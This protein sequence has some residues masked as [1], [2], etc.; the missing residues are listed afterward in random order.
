MLL[1][2]GGPPPAWL[3]PLLKQHLL[4]E[5]HHKV[6]RRLLHLLAPL[7]TEHH[8][9]ISTRHGTSPQ[10]IRALQ[11]PS[12]VQGRARPATGSV[13]GDASSK[14]PDQAMHYEQAASAERAVHAEHSVQD[15]EQFHRMT[16]EARHLSVR[17]EGLRCLGA[18]L[19]PI[20]H[21]LRETSN[22]SL[23]SGM[24]QAPDL[25]HTIKNAGQPQ[26]T[27]PAQS[28]LHS[29]EAHAAQ[30]NT[31]APGQ[32]QSPSLG[33]DQAQPGS[34]L[35]QIRGSV[36]DPAHPA[37]Q[38]PSATEAWQPGTHQHTTSGASGQ[39]E[40][41]DNLEQT[42]YGLVDDFIRLIRRSSEAQQ[43]DDMR[44]AAATALEAS[45]ACFVTLSPMSYDVHWF[46]DRLSPKLL[47]L[48]S[49]HPGMLHMLCRNVM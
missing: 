29:S 23:S 10:S 46:V 25:E 48:C 49:V 32:H 44:L 33:S 19:K 15:F 4:T 18:A 34:S 1:I 12:A 45:G 7:P 16:T 14:S 35:H 22:A 30:L 8:G 11:P 2:A 39:A 26:D 24:Q 27:E 28:P 21:L 38:V 13:N 40:S 6:L 36:D 47:G 20:L 42:L 9:L 3:P 37:Q 17:R 43:F 31:S 5:R 41:V